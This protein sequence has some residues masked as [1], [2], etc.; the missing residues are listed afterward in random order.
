MNRE[1]ASES[2]SR[3]KLGQVAEF[4]LGA[5]RVSPARRQIQVNGETRTLEPRVMQVLVALA[6]ARPDV[7]P[8]DELVDAVWGGVTVG[9][10][11]INRCIVSLRRLAR[12]F[13]P[14]PFAIETV[15]RVGYSLKELGKEGPPELA[16]RVSNTSTGRWWRV[17]AAIVAAA[18]MIAGLILWWQPWRSDGISIAVVPATSSPS[19]AELAR[20]LTAKLGMLPSVTDGSTRLLDGGGRADFTFEADTSNEGGQTGGNL[21]LRNNRKEIIWSKDFHSASPTLGDLK[22][23]A[24]F[25]A[26]KVLECAIETRGGGGSQLTPELVKAYLNGCAQF[27]DSN[28]DS[29]R[30]LVSTFTRVADRA[31]AFRAVWPRLLVTAEQAPVLQTNPDFRQLR[32]LTDRAK[33]IDRGMPEISIAEAALARPADVT[34]RMKLIETAVQRNPDNRNALNSYVGY[35]GVVGREMDSVAVAKR[36]VTLDPISPTA[37]EQV[38]LALAMAGR[39]NDADLEL[40]NAEALWPG[41]LSL[42]GARYLLYLRF[43]DPKEAIRLRNAGGWMPGGAT[44]Q[45]SFLTA[46]ADPTPANIEKALGDARAF[47]AK[48]P[49]TLFNLI[50]TLGAFGR[51][52]EAFAILLD[53]KH[54]IDAES[55][56]VVIFRPALHKLRRDPRFMRVAKRIGLLDYWEASGKWPDLCYEPDLPYDCK[57]EA[58]KLT[59]R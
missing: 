15:P 44:Y 8:R 17:P 36:A 42:R 26:A 47:Y 38:V 39:L 40:R 3:V 55:V 52:E 50:Q 11:A 53:E 51:E 10:D 12:E 4:N 57:A 21:I 7:V 2:G 27:A 43:G 29:I 25:T 13:D 20:D 32:Q 28:E 30:D 5:M 33:K 1:F 49:G 58:A 59:E 37:R 45:I 46:R 6:E 16:A 48:E 34:T 9:D 22:Q 41:S 23:Q 35:L 24:G 56:L 19:S 14:Q 54:P 18:A 31:P